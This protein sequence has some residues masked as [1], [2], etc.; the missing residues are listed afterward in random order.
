MSQVQALDVR[1]SWPVPQRRRR[2]PRGRLI[3]VL[4][5][6]LPAV[7]LALIG[8][9]VL[10]PQIMGG[11]SGLIVPIFNLGDS[12]QTTLLRMD[13]PRYVGQTNRGE[14]YEL[15]A[16]S[17]SLDPLAPNLI[18]LDQLAADLARVDGDVRLTAMNGTYDRDAENVLLDGGIEVHTSSGYRFAT[19]SAKVILEDGR[20]IGW[21]PIQGAGPAG[22]LSA[23]RF[24]IRDGGDV[25]HFNGHVKVT[26]LPQAKADNPDAP[27]TVRGRSS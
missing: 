7:A 10:W 18:H 2:K 16:H 24:E 19:P 15:T 26:L 12:D 3:D 23:D 25:L 11:P 14:P 5:W 6:L 17:A 22:A 4:R 20:V 8:L 9:V 21:Q 1:R 13:G 27:P